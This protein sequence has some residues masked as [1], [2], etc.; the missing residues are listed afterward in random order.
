MRCVTVV[1]QTMQR[2]LLLKCKGL[3]EANVLDKAEDKQRSEVTNPDGLSKEA[4]SE[5]LCVALVAT[6]VF[7]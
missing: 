1:R 4:F 6:D 7:T 3:T 5:P 2:T